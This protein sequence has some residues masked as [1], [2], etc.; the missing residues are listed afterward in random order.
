MV[1]DRN[2][3][4]YRLAI[5]AL[6]LILSCGNSLAEHP[7]LPEGWQ[8]EQ[9]ESVQQR[10]RKPEARPTPEAS[11]APASAEDSTADHRDASG[12]Q[13]SEGAGDYSFWGEPPAQWIMARTSVLSMVIAGLAVALVWLTLREAR[14]TTRAAI[15]SVVQARRAT[16]ATEKSVA[17]AH[18][19]GAR[20]IRAY[21]AFDSPE[22]QNI[23]GPGKIVFK[24]KVANNGGTPA[25]YVVIKSFVGLYRHRDSGRFVLRDAEKS[26]MAI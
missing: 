13:P 15:R 8:S 9:N 22:V 24:C 14:R 19:I 2:P 23:P 10:E 6:G 18:D 4:G 26:P 17:V 11:A 7:G 1:F 25:R 12:R 5:F 20:Q 21:L 16:A 3:R